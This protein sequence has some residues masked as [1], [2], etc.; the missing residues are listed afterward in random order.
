M[1]PSIPP[2]GGGRRRILKIAAGDARSFDDDLPN[3]T[4]GQGLS[5]FVEND[6]LMIGDGKPAGNDLFP[7]AVVAPVQSNP[8][9]QDRELAS[10]FNRDP[11]LLGAG[12]KVL[13]H[14]VLLPMVLRHGFRFTSSLFRRELSGLFAQSVD[15]RLSSLIGLSRATGPN[16]AL[17]LTPIARARTT[18]FD[19]G[20]R[21][22]LGKSASVWLGTRYQGTNLPNVPKW[23]GALTLDWLHN[24]WSASADAFY[25]GTHPT[26]ITTARRIDS[27]TGVVNEVVTR[28]GTAS[29][30]AGVNLHLRRA[31]SAGM[32]ASLSVYN[33]GGAQF[34][35]NFGTQTT[36]IA[37]LSAP[38]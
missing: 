11:F 8:I 18:G 6:Q 5:F 29:A 36:V 24:G 38:L 15:P 13:N 31:L 20:V 32:S 28:T 12:G 19:Q 16:S 26:A 33:L 2:R 23:Q 34:Y 22:D 37:G 21:A 4:F 17:A 7:F 14:E 10:G 9:D 30:T 25:L 3:F 35:P 1:Q 27:R